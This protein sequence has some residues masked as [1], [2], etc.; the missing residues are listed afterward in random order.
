MACYLLLWLYITSC[1]ERQWKTF[2]L[3]ENVATRPNHCIEYIYTSTCMSYWILYACVCVWCR[4]CRR[5]ATADGIRIAHCTVYYVYNIIYSFRPNLNLN[6]HIHGHAMHLYIYIRVSVWVFSTCSRMVDRLAHT[7]R[8]MHAMA[9]VPSSLLAMHACMQQQQRLSSYDYYYIS[10]FVYFIYFFFFVFFSLS[11]Y[12]S[13]FSLFLILVHFRFPMA[14]M[15]WMHNGGIGCTH[16]Q[17]S[18]VRRPA[19]TGIGAHRSEHTVRQHIHI[20]C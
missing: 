2:G 4:R 10:L 6:S 1:A 9:V 14:N 18:V 11:L 16:W 13:F 3:M 5:H 17:R 15:A 8:T 12:F 19:W 7:I 20:A